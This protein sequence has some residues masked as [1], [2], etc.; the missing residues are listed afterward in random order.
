MNNAAVPG[1]DIV[2]PEK[3]INGGGFVS[4]YNSWLSRSIY[5]VFITSCIAYETVIMKGPDLHMQ[6][7]CKDRMNM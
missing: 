7:T 1:L 3:F 2:S 4:V 6:G 5:T